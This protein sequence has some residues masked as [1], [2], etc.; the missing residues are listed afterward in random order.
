MKCPELVNYNI[1]GASAATVSMLL[2]S[3]Y[4]MHDRQFCV[5]LIKNIPAKLELM[6][7]IEGVQVAE[8]MHNKWSINLDD[9]SILGVY[10]PSVK[11]IVF[12][13]FHREYGISNNT[14]T[15][16]IAR[17][18]EIS[19]T[20]ILGHGILVNPNV[21]LAPYCTLTNHVTINRNCSV[22]HHTHVG[23]YSTVNPGVNIA[24]NCRIGKGVTIGMGAN[25]LDGVSIG[26]GTIIGAGSLVVK[27]I[28]ENV[29]AF[30][31]PAKIKSKL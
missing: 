12:D 24:G 21:T 17:N 31:V 14:F 4:S 28:P 19:Q 20:S 6:Y 3:M 16:L 30:G 23:E 1:L 9:K 5:K 25:I 8:M 27:N 2:E 29:K 13:F 22:G 18:S 26:D 11:K 7:Q 10:L 15:N